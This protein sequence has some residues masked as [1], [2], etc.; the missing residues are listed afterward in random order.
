M[1]RIGVTGSGGSEVRGM[2]PIWYF[3]GWMLLVVGVILAATGVYNWH[4]P[5]SGGV[6]LSELHADFWWGLVLFVAGLAFYL[7]NRKRLVS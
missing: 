3:V 2:R 7:F 5:P 4:H 1:R 6:R